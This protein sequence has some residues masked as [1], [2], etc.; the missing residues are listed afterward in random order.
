MPKVYIVTGAPGSGKS[1]FVNQYAGEYDIVYDFDRIAEALCPQSGAHG[2][3]RFM[4]DLLMDIRK[5]VIR[6]LS[7][8]IGEWS[9]AYFITSSADPVQIRSWLNMMKAEE[10]HIDTPLDKCIENI[11]AD[12]S[13]PHKQQQIDLARDYFA[14]R[15]L[16]ER[17]SPELNLGPMP[18]PDAGQELSPFAKHLLKAINR[19]ASNTIT[20]TDPEDLRKD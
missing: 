7:S 18:E 19:R 2:N 14:K 20:E 3:R 8:G 1:H 6:N 15:K 4:M 10:I 16:A 13:R 17:Q 9:N 5:T 11:M 12:D